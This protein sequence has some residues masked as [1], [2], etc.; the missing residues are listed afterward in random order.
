MLRPGRTVGIYGSYTNL[1]IAL[2]EKP[3]MKYVVA[4]KS[5]EEVGER[6]IV[7]GIDIISF[8]LTQ[9]NFFRYHERK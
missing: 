7:S 9:D 3:L 6:K 4:Y 1:I 8:D 5:T 2:T